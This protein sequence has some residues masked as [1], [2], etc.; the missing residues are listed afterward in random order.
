[1]IPIL[2]SHKVESIITI[3]PHD[4]GSEGLSTPYDYSLNP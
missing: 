1:M 2:D 4:Y 3:E